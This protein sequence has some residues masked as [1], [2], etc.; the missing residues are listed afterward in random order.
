MTRA[1]P[2]VAIHD[3]RASGWCLQINANAASAV[4]PGTVRDGL[5]ATPW[6]ISL[7][8]EPPITTARWPHHANRVGVLE[9][10]GH[11]AEGEQREQEGFSAG[12]VGEASQPRG[13]P[14]AGG[15]EFQERDARVAHEEFAG[16]TERVQP[17]TPDPRLR[18]PDRLGS[19]LVR[20]LGEAP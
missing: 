20:V 3:P 7:S 17:L 5:P 18:H 9:H 14:P 1:V 4:K 11:R 2:R 13:G 16:A 10:L 19:Q 12:K 8:T 15:I 6:V